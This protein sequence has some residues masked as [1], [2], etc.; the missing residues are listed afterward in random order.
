MACVTSTVPQSKGLETRHRMSHGVNRTKSI[1]TLTGMNRSI[2]TPDLITALIRIPRTPATTNVVHEEY[3]T[4]LDADLLSS[5]NFSADM[6]ASNEIS[7]SL[8]QTTSKNSRNE[9][10]VPNGDINHPMETNIQASNGSLVS[11]SNVHELMH[12]EIDCDRRTSINSIQSDAKRNILFQNVGRTLQRT[13][14]HLKRTRL[15]HLFYFLALPVYTIIG[16]VIFQANIHLKLTLLNANA[17]DARW[18]TRR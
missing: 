9:L 1:P 2:S 7:L 14:S 8:E 10:T 6:E 3:V 15:L 17:L 11:F 16:A 5:L 4:N 18:R 12:N 13:H